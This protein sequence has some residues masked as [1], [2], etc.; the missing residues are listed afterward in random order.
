MPARDGPSKANTPA[1]PD[2]SGTRVALILLALLLAFHAGTNALH[3]TDRYFWLDEASTYQIASQPLAEIVPA[4]SKSHLQPPLFYW[5]AHFVSD[6]ADTPGVLRGISFTL[7]ACTLAFTMLGLGE[8][9]IPARLLL[10]T[11]LVL[12]PVTAYVAT[13]FRPY[14]LALFFVLLSSILLF[15]ALPAT[16]R[17]SPA[18]WYGLS[19]LGLQYSL[20]LNCWVFACQMFVVGIVTSSAAREGG[21]KAA[22]E[23]H[24]RL[25]T[26]CCVLSISYAVFLLWIAAAGS[27]WSPRGDAA[28]SWSFW[29]HLRR[30]FATAMLPAVMAARGL[31]GSITWLAIGL[32]L[33]GVVLTFR[34]NILWAAYL[35]A[36]FIGQLLF[37]TSLLYARIE[38]FHFRYLVASFV[39]FALLAA[40]GYEF[41]VV[42]RWPG[43]PSLA[44]P[45]LLLVL[46]LPAALG[47]FTRARALPPV[48]NPYRVLLDDI[49]CPAGEARLYCLPAWSCSPAAY[50]FRRSAAIEVPGSLSID[51]VHMAGNRR[52]CLFVF[53][54]LVGR[55]S[56]SEQDALDYLNASSGFSRDTIDLHLRYP[57]LTRFN[58]FPDYLHIYR[59]HDASP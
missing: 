30:N 9:S 58:Q 28:G 43:K 52:Q 18:I 37:S 53:A 44:A 6:F 55:K 11:L 29:I 19:A 47:A 20:L 23:R 8:L 10:S 33:S 54:T 46:L 21:V 26:I 48:T 13:E 25:I 32:F 35:L 14:A 16:R 45:L 27:A 38:W 51:Q 50:E 34:R 59:P 41:L 17:W 2:S 42:R 22:F 31:G 12:S 24:G 39:A 57:Q 56:P 3:I 40:F 15:R 1:S 7:V 4:L 5:L 49:A 36:I